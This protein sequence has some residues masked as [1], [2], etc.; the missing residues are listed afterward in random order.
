FAAVSHGDGDVAQKT[1]A[2]SA[3]DGR[4]FEPAFEFSGV[5]AGEPV[6]RR[7]DE[8]GSR[9]H[10]GVSGDWSFAIPGAD[11]LTDV[12]AEDLATNGLAQLFGDD[13]FFFDGEIGDAAGGVHLMRSYECIGRA[14][15]DASG[16]ASAAVG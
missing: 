8:F 11:V 3:F 1:C 13:A 16:A 9:D 5:H 12:A 2:A 10:S 4:A 6:E 14:G 7:V 15:V